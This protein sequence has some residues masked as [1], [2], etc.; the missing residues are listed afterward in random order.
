V[1]LGRQLGAF[2][3]LGHEAN[4][5][6]RFDTPRASDRNAQDSGAAR[7]GDLRKARRPCPASFSVRVQSRS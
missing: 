2:S 7:G 6:L 4:D 5:H 3:D 1:K